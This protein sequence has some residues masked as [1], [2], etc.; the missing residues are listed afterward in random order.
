[1]AGSK[2]TVIESASKNAVAIPPSNDHRFREMLQQQA[3][4][5]EFIP[6]LSGMIRGIFFRR[7]FWVQFVPTGLGLLWSAWYYWKSRQIWNWRQHGP[8][9]LVVSLLTTPYSWMTDE[10]VL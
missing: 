7:Y 4:Q 10:V 2:A 9:V 6:A 1:M 5:H 8:A 3:I